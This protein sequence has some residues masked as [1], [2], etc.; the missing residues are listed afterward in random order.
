MAFGQVFE[1]PDG[2]RQF[3]GGFIDAFPDIAIESTNLFA[4][5]DQVASEFRVR[6]THTGTLRGPG[7][8]IPPTQN[9]IDY[10]VAEVW[11]LRDSRVTELHNYFDSG[12]LMRQLGLA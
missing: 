11:R 8:D 4:S 5:D 12:T 3:A 2:F 10:P 1:G 7:G 9:R 6:G